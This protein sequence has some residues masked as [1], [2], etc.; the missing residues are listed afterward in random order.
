MMRTSAQGLTLVELVVTVA[1]VTVLLAVT[2]PGFR[3]FIDS[4]SVKAASQS[5][6]EDF[7]LA[8]SEAIKRSAPVVL[9]A[10]STGTACGGS[11]LWKDG[12]M[13]YQPSNTINREY[14][15][16]DEIIRVQG[17]LRNI[18][19]I[20]SPS[21]STK[22]RFVFEATGWAKA[23]TQTFEVAPAGAEAGAKMALMAKRLICVSNNGRASLQARE[24]TA[25]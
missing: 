3:T 21:G 23:A 8:R 9:C 17:P 14:T 10:S 11:G 12:W 13:V 16:G 25:C 20:K 7:R 4:Q 6:L 2:V 19:S 18:E 24:A 1:V 22:P 15:T 5:L